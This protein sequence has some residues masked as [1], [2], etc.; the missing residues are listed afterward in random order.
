[1]D[2]FRHFLTR[3]SAY[4]KVDSV[5]SNNGVEPT[6]AAFRE[7]CDGNEIRQELTASDTPEL[8][9]VIERELNMN[10]KSAEAAALEAPRRVLDISI[11]VSGRL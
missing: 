3:V 9:G 2:T 6:S 5:H 4:G 11:P 1:M 10:L 8:N 7:V